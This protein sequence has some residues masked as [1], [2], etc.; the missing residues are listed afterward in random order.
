MYYEFDTAEG[1]IVWTGH[2]EGV[3]GTWASAVSEFPLASSTKLFTGVAAMYTMQL[4][5]DDFYPEKYLHEFEGWE[6]FKNF[7]VA[8]TQE[9]ANLTVHQL[10]THTSGLPFAL[11]DSKADL[12]NMHLFFQPGTGF[13]YTL[14]HRIIG[15]LLR[16]FWKEQPETRHIGIKT[17]GDAYKWLLFD[18][19]KL[20]C[21]T[22][23]LG[24]FDEIF[25]FSGEAA[26]A[27]M[28][29]TGEDFMKL[30]VFA[31]RRGQLPSGERLISEANW[32]KW[33]VPNLLPGGKLSEDLV[34]WRHAPANW[35]NLNVGG[36]KEKIMRQSGNYGWNYF[37]ATYHGSNEI[38]WCGFFSSCLRVSYEQDLAFVF[39]QRDVADLKH[40]KDYVAENF[41]EMARSLQC[42][43]RKCVGT[44]QTSVFCENCTIGSSRDVV[45]RTR[46]WTNTCERE[47]DVGSVLKNDV[48]WRDDSHTCYVPLCRQA[49]SLGNSR[50]RN[51]TGG[52]C[53]IAHCDKSRGPTTCVRGSC[54]CQE[55]SCEQGGKCV[56][57][58]EMSPCCQ[59]TGGTCRVFG[60]D[61][62]RGETEC[63]GRWMFLTGSCKCKA[64]YCAEAGR[65]IKRSE[66]KTTWEFIDAPSELAACG[67]SAV[68]EAVFE[69]KAALPWL[70]GTCITVL[71]M[72]LVFFR[73]LKHR[74]MRPEALDSYT[75]LAGATQGE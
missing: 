6:E 34:S 12:L 1:D 4:R 74:H 3:G 49:P 56:K 42:A 20:S 71:T 5:P 16:D 57:P 29:S 39:M 59:D 41:P 58:S 11:R 17:V 63:V 52:T 50:C 8:G 53:S 61:A 2:A 55:G 64:G 21:A 28:A 9:R 67:G 32:N 26:D 10:L 65:C 38:G 19:L 23:F 27:A 33:A 46:S 35:K 75:L 69:L 70:C 13:G 43:R 62:S 24:I 73:R 68:N 48:A 40:S 36:V 51:D 31:L 7:P 18:R 30:A 37:G 22:R 25:G 47:S 72:A 45:C 54:L 60:C 44:E 14:G 15:W 66:L